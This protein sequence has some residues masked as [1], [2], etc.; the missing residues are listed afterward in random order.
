[1]SAELKG[2]IEKWRNSP[3]GFVWTTKMREEC[4]DELEATLAAAP[5]AA[6]PPVSESAWLVERRASAIEWLCAWSGGFEWTTDSLK[7][8]RFCR[9]EDA[10]QIG[11]IFDDEDIHITEHT[12]Q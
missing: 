7:A 1:M 3:T 5:Q 10:N 11:E 9:R 8:I 2:L 12:W 4:A 6:A